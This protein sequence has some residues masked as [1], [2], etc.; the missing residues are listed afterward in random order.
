MGNHI[1]IRTE[2]TQSMDA[3]KISCFYEQTL[4]VCYE[5]VQEDVWEEKTKPR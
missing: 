1:K 3:G 4:K 5:G 2:I